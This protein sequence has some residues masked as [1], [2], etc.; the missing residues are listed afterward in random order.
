[1]SLSTNVRGRRRAMLVLGFGLVACLWAATTLVDRR[2]ATLRVQLDGDMRSLWPQGGA[3][4][5]RQ[6]AVR[7]LFGTDD[8]LFVAW[9]GDDLFTSNHLAAWRALSL[10]LTGLPGVAQVESLATL[11]DV[12]DSAEGADIAPM[13][14][15]IPAD[16]A[17]A[18]AVRARALGHPLARDWLVGR[19]GT[20]LALVLRPRAGQDDA[21]LRALVATVQAR[22]S[23]AAP[24]LAQATS[25]PLALRLELAR[26]LVRDLLLITPLAMLA[27][28]LVAA[29]GLGSAVHA[30]IA[31]LQNA[32]TT[33]LTLALFVYGGH[34]LDFVTAGLAP[35]VYVVGFAYAMHMLCAYQQQRR[36]GTARDAASMQ[37]RRTVARPLALTALTTVLGFLALAVSSLP[38]IRVFGLYV[39]LGVALAWVGAMILVPALLALGPDRVGAGG[40]KWAPLAQQ[41]IRLLLPRRV[42]V[43]AATAVVAGAA[44]L[45]ATQLRVD[46]AVLDNF[47]ADHPLVAGFARLSAHFAG[48]VPLEILVESRGANGFHDPESLAA[49]AG[50]ARALGA[51]PGV[52]GVQ[53]LHD[54]VAVLHA[55]LD[56]DA[57]RQQPWPR[58]ARA[59]RH[60]LLLADHAEIG[61]F[62][63]AEGRR[64]LLR[65]R[66]SA[67]STA[68]VNALAAR[69]E[70]ELALVPATIEAHLTGTTYLSAAAIDA[71]ARGQVVGL[72]LAFCAIGVVLGCA[73]RSA[74][75]GLL[76]LVPNVLPIVVFFGLLGVL[77]VSLNLTTSLVACAVFGVAVDDTVHLLARYLADADFPARPAVALATSLSEVLRPVTLTTAALCAGFATLAFSAL[78]LQAE[79]GLLA[80]AT[81]ACAWLVDV[82]VAPAMFHDLARPSKSGSE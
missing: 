27:T 30:L 47:A 2:T 60:E 34:R 38:S 3:S 78:R 52:E 67:S 42:G 69:I 57:A 55:A 25:G 82:S 22:T 48:P 23:A 65:V 43:L 1:M 35:V 73:C 51:L 33:V 46:T 14:D 54:Y 81:L 44:L 50:L 7:A 62:V 53:G 61:R 12:R 40:A 21:A 16:Q 72:A 11:V 36:A 41:L 19:D 45:A 5:A 13:L 20:A 68:A 77:P 75:I 6:D 66:S 80:A 26:L 70:E 71:L 58:S 59:V 4:R 29:W 39:A 24:M 79:F 9:F 49:L 31:L 15:A 74:R 10:E 18:D 63:D 32:M 17:A 76:A 37:A 64:A 28:W 8:V 56:P